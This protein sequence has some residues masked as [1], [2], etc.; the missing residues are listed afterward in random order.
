[1]KAMMN[2]GKTL[3]QWQEK[4]KSLYKD[5]RAYSREHPSRVIIGIGVVL[6][7]YSLLLG[8]NSLFVHR[9][10]ARRVSQLEKQLSQ[11]KQK[12]RRD[13]VQLNWNLVD[14]DELEHIARTKFNFKK[15]EEVVFILVDSSTLQPVNP[16]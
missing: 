6:I 7:L 13:S 5:F 8:D 10:Y 4:L 2:G 16:D 15:P 11:S 1:M 3:K 14:R 9:K 12:F